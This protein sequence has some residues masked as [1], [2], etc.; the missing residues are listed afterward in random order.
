MINNNI[1][2][3]LF[4]LATFTLAGMFV[5]GS[6]SAA[7]GVSATTIDLS[8]QQQ[9]TQQP[10]KKKKKKVAPRRAAPHVTA[11]RRAP[12]H[13]VPRVV[14][15]HRAA[16]RHAAPRVV[17]PPH[18]APRIGAP[19]GVAPKTAAPPK[20]GGKVLAPRGVGPKVSGRKAPRKFTPRGPNA[21]VVT[22]SRLRGLPARGAGRASIRGR[23]YSVWRHGHRVRHRGGW[24]TFIALGMLA[25]IVIGADEFFYP[26]AYISAPEP[27]CEGLTEDGCWLVWENVETLEGDIIPQCVAY[28]PWQ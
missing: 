11:P 28:C 6:H 2:M 27:Y 13:A 1:K 17:T 5:P 10:Q 26:Y 25:P 18:T 9:Q 24:Y 19:V 7:Q 16:P 12:R 23:H 4:T 15:P 14:T 20:T 3:T 21:R 8:A 22:T